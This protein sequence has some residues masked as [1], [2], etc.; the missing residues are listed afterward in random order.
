MELSLQSHKMG[1]VVVIRCGGRIVVGAEITS[2]QQELE[3]LTVLTKKVVLHLGEVTFIDSVGLGALVRQFGVLRAKGGDLKLCMVS[4]FLLQVLQVT[5]LLRVFPMHASEEEAIQAF[6][7]GKQFHDETFG[8]SKTRIVCIDPSHDLLAYVSALLKRSGY[9]VITTR[10]P[11]DALLFMRVTKP[12]ILICGPGMQAN[13]TA[14]KG[15]AELKPS[16]HL[17]HLP[18]DFSTGEA[19]QAG[20]NLVN[21]VRQLLSDHQGSAGPGSP[22]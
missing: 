20:T 19:G 1:D 10:N 14:M 9:E 18:S 4:P 12:Q 13:E 22:S 15:F 7:R 5:N 11:S 2:L 16:V 6:S 17:L 8:A 21:R 3:K